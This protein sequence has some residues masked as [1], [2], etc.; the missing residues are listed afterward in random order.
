MSTTTSWALFHAILVPASTIAEDLVTPSRQ[1]QAPWWWY[2]GTSHRQYSYEESR[3]LRIRYQILLRVAYRHLIFRIHIVN[4][5]VRLRTVAPLDAVS[6]SVAPFDATQSPF[7]VSAFEGVI[8]WL[9]R[10]QVLR[11]TILA[12]PPSVY[13]GEV[14]LQHFFAREKRRCKSQLW[15]FWRLTLQSI[16]NLFCLRVARLLVAVLLSVLHESEHWQ[17]SMYPSSTQNHALRDD[18]V[19]LPRIQLTSYPCHTA[20]LIRSLSSRFTSTRSNCHVYHTSTRVAL[21]LLK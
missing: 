20:C 6:T 7:G 13:H 18:R 9:K 16:L 12:R 8:K 3:N 10:K 15:G 1:G 11:S 5:C 19:S 4:L 14:A 21:F 17:V 2:L